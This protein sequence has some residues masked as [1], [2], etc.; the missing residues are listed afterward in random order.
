MKVD[1]V[2][3]VMKVKLQELDDLYFPL[4]PE[5]SENGEVIYQLKLILGIWSSVEISIW[6]AT[7]FSK[8]TR[9]VISIVR[10]ARRDSNEGLEAIAKICIN[11]DYLLGAWNEVALTIS[12]D[13]EG[14]AS[15]QESTEY[16]KHE[17]YMYTFPFLW[18]CMHAWS[19]TRKHKKL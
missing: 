10:Q 15:L 14:K 7:P 6:R 18:Q 8:N 1:N 9:E 19:C 2:F 13:D 3:S 12:N 5:R 11:T 17:K 16:T 4:L